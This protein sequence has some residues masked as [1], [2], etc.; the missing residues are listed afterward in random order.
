MCKVND[1]VFLQ[2]G[3]DFIS[4]IMHLPIK[5]I[6]SAC[7]IYQ[8]KL[9]TDIEFQ[10][11]TLDQDIGALAKGSMSLYSGG[12]VSTISMSSFSDSMKCLQLKRSLNS[13][14]K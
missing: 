6:L 5:K 2:K 12:S 11:S 8:C 13:L 4:V 14:V 10:T 3:E 1:F 9:F 7:I